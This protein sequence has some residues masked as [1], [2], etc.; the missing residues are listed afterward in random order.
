MADQHTTMLAADTLEIGLPDGRTAWLYYHT[1]ESCSSLDVWTT[2]DREVEDVSARTGDT[3]RAP[4]GVI[5]WRNGDR[6]TLTDRDGN[7]WKASPGSHKW[8]AAA[9]VVLVWDEEQS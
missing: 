8:P 2:R 5:A 3:T 4:V 6:A 7:D 1:C 9:T